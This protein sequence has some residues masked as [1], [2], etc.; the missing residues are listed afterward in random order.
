MTWGQP[1]DPLPVR[2][3]LL[4]QLQRRLE[5]EGRLPSAVLVMTAVVQA[6]VDDVGLARLLA[7]GSD[8]ARLH[9]LIAP[10]LR[11]CEPLMRAALAARPSRD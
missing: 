8:R 4:E 2:A 11:R 10:S 3:Y 6:I 7:C 9:R 5:A 1:P